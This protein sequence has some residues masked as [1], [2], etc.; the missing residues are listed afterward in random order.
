MDADEKKFDRIVGTYNRLIRW[1]CW[2]RSWNDGALCRELMQDVYI[3]IWRRLPTIAD[4][5]GKRR[6]AAWVTMQCRSVFS[7]RRRQRDNNWVEL[8]T[9]IA[10]TISC[11][12]TSDTTETI[13][14]LTQGLT[15]HELHVLK[16]ITD[17][18]RHDE[19]AAQLGIKPESVRII[20]HRIVQ[21]MRRTYEQNNQ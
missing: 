19:I 4:D 11:D 12:S 21:K 10:D 5:A 2:Q 18:Y 3:A 13:A 1:L 17:G 15:A 8:D 6:E 20:R 9:A 14:D 16:L 7:H